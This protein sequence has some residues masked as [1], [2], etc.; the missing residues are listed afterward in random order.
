MHYQL[1]TTFSYSR[2]PFLFIFLLFIL[3]LLPL[4]FHKFLSYPESNVL[5]SSSTG[6]QHTRHD[7]T[8]SYPVDGNCTKPMKSI[9]TI[10]CYFKTMVSLLVLSSLQATLVIIGSTTSS[11]IPNHHQ[12]DFHHSETFCTFFAAPRF[13]ILCNYSWIVKNY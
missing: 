8:I 7:W 5:S 6:E 3:P 12:Y 9:F 4:E 10:H 11:F 13:P 1:I 2:K